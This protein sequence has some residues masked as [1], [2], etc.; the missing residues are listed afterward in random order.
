M[1]IPALQL[2]VLSNQLQISARS[3]YRKLER[4]GLK[5]HRHPKMKLLSTVQAVVQMRID[6]PGATLQDIGDKIGVSK[7]RVHRIL[8]RTRF[9]N[10]AQFSKAVIRML[11]V[12]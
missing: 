7:Q 1:L 6:N 5:L 8:K 9:A 3:A 11:C 12:Q 10:E 4:L 2:K